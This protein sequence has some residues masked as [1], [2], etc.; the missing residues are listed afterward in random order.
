MR[1]FLAGLVW[2]WTLLA[3]AAP[4]LVM[5]LHAAELCGSAKQVGPSLSEPRTQA[6]AHG[7]LSSGCPWCMLLRHG[8][9]LHAVRSENAVRGAPTR[10]GRPGPRVAARTELLASSLAPRAPPRG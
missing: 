5:H 7:G 6:P 2:L 1:R 8:A 4:H 3:F 10:L 9:R